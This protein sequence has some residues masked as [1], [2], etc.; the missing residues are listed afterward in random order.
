MDFNPKHQL[1]SKIV[2]E[3]AENEIKPMVAE[4]D[5]ESRFPHEIVEKMKPLHFF[6]LQ[7]PKTLGGAGLDTIS[8]AI[9]VEEL[10]RVSAAL[11]LCVTVH[12]SVGIYPI[13]EFGT[14][15]QINRFVPAMA[16]GESIGAFCL[17]EANA[18]SDAGGVE[19]S[20]RE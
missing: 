17:T 4:M 10:S 3:F 7:V 14:K 5:R 13:L 20:A 18:G 16:A 9:V 8:Y 19:T 12:N 1:I 11:G 2:R 6:G 15:E